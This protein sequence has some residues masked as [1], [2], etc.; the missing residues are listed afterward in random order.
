M[1]TDIRIAP[2]VGRKLGWYVYLYID[3]FDGKVFYVG[4]GRGTRV[5]SHL[6]DP[7]DNRKCAII[8]RIRRAGGEPR[9]EILAHGLPSEETALRVEAAA[10]D[11]LSLPSLANEVRGWRSLQFGRVSL[12]DLI[13]L[14]ERRRVEIREPAVFIRI[15]RL[16]HPRMRPA[17]LYEATRGVWRVGPKRSKALYALAVFEGIVRE[18]YEI[19]GW[20]PANS[21]FTTR[22][23]SDF[24]NNRWEFVGRLAS[25]TLRRRYVNGYVGHL[26]PQGAQNPMGAAPLRRR[27]LSFISRV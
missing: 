1:T 25:E 10:I 16:Y 18:V 2:S 4:K 12:S 11:L 23:A 8:R 20:F 14:Y 7:S 3:P 19:A 24:G 22:D 5:L 17:E 6:D 15:R 26:F 13:T 9:I 21:T 27:I